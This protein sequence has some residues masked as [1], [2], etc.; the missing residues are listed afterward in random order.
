M[1]KIK[2]G[3]ESFWIVDC[4]ISREFPDMTKVFSAFRSLGI[5]NDATILDVGANIGLFTLSY[6]TL[7]KNS[8][9]YSFEPVD[10]IFHN[11]NKSIKFNKKYKGRIKTFKYGFSDKNQD[12]GLSMPTAK[13]HPRYSTNLAD[14]LMSIHGKGKKKSKGSFITL[15][16]FVRTEKIEA[17]DFIMIDVEGHEF[18][19]LSGG[20]DSISKFKPIIQLEFN[21]LTKVLSQYSIVDFEDLLNGFGY[22]FY[23]LEYGWPD[24]YTPLCS[25]KETQNINVSDIVCI[26]ESRKVFNTN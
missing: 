9:V 13:Q 5:K 16:N 21:D 20:K 26:N 2:L 25:L 8:N 23:G 15:D 7:F 19:V 10:Y 3:T 22:S 4:K 12:L 17:I 11:L 1:K 14:G 6:L 18:E 24:H